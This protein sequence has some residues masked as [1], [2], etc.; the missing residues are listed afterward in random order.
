MLSFSS[1]YKVEMKMFISSDCSEGLSFK[2]QQSD[3]IIITPIVECL[4]V[5]HEGILQNSAV[6]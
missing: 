2:A 5:N 3:I 4:V 1:V 6:D